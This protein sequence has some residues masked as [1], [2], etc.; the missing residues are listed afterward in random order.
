[1]WVPLFLDSLFGSIHLC[2][3][4]L[5]IPN[6]LIIILLYF[7]HIKTRWG[8]F[9]S[10]VLLNNSR[11]FSQF[12]VFTSEFENQ[13]ITSYQKKKKPTGNLFGIY[14]SICG[15]LQSFFFF[16]RIAILTI[17]SSPIHEHGIY[18]FYFDFFFNSLNNIL[19]LSLYRFWASFICVFPKYFMG[20]FLFV[21]GISVS[22]IV[23]KFCLSFVYCKYIRI[24]FSLS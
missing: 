1:M 24:Q 13:L 2:V 21:F 9:S 5:S 23:L 18:V 16:F 22:G 11:G 20:G 7:C 12:F 15:E 17:S 4:P 10:L 6:S 19:Q 14:R 3:C 8:K